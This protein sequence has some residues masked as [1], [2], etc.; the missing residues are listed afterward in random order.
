MM[1]MI[2]ATKTLRFSTAT[3]FHIHVL[4]PLVS[5]N[6]NALVIGFSF[7]SGSN[8]FLDVRSNNIG[9]IFLARLT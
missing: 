9:A 6:L 4:L 3:S 5:E 7:Y 1:D 8:C 2:S